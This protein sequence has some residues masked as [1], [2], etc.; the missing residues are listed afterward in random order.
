MTRDTRG[1]QLSTAQR[2]NHLPASPLCSLTWWFEGCAHILPPGRTSIEA[3]PQEAPLP[4]LLWA[5]PQTLPLTSWNP[6]PVHTLTILLQPDALHHL[7]GL[8]AGDWVN[9]W[10][11]AREVLPPD[12]LAICAA[13]FEPGDDAT[14]VALL[15]D[16]LEPRWQAARPALPMQAQRYLDWAQSLAMHAAVTGP[17]RSLRQIERRIKR[18]AGLPMR[19]LRGIGRAEQVFFEAQAAMERGHPNWA[20]LADASGYADQSHLCRETRRITGFSPDELYRRI[21]SDESF[22]SYRLWQ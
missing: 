6:G 13:L 8:A 22:W 14:R 17:G 9:R 11:D 20:E 2:H 3:P 16:F 5:G 10:C 1:A 7:T 12:W 21:V 4:T 18:W 15:E 19:E